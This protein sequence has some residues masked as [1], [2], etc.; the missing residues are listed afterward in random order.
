MPLS[1]SSPS[2]NFN[3]Y[4]ETYTQEHYTIH[5]NCT[6]LARLTSLSIEKTVVFLNMSYTSTRNPITGFIS[7][8]RTTHTH[9]IEHVHT[10]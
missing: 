7:P 2:S 8:Q 3:R 6:S 1:F 5:V 4:L 10:T 9:T